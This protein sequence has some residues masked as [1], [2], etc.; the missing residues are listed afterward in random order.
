M[1]KKPVMENGGARGQLH[2]LTREHTLTGC[3]HRRLSAVV[4]S[5]EA[6]VAD[7]QDVRV[8]RFQP[9]QLLVTSC[10]VPFEN[11]PVATVGVVA[12]ARVNAACSYQKL[13]RRLL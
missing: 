9:E 11:V 2:E 4:S 8:I 3:R 5:Q 12:P 6:S 10:C 13:C 1:S 7:R